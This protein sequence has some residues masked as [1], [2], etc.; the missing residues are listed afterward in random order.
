MSNVSW[1]IIHPATPGELCQQTGEEF[2]ARLGGRPSQVDSD[3]SEEDGEEREEDNLDDL[4]P[5][6]AQMLL[7]I[8]N[9]FNNLLIIIFLII[10][11]ISANWCKI[12]CSWFQESKWQ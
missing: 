7:I 10:Y 6:T 11:S 3:P 9:F 4:Y 1:M 12:Y 2:K 8:I 5:R